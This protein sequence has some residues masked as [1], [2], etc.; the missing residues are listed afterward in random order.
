MQA[1]VLVCSITSRERV[2]SNSLKSLPFRSI[3]H[4]VLILFL[5]SLVL[6][7]AQ[8]P[9]GQLKVS[10]DTT[11]INIGDIV[12]LSLSIQYPSSAK[13]TF[14]PVGN[15]L[16]EWTVRNVKNIPAKGLKNG[17]QEVGLQ[18]QLAIYKI[19][20]FN[21]P[22]MEVELIKKNSE[23][24]VLSSAPIKIKVESILT[25][26]KQKLKDLKAQA[27]IAPDYRPFLLL[28]AAL[29]SVAFLIYWLFTTLKKR[30][31]VAMIEVLDNRTP[32]Q[33]ARDAIQALLSRRLVEQSLLKQFYLELSE[34][35]KR[36][37]G[38]KLNI[39]SLERTTEEFIRD[40][41]KTSLAL[42]DFEMIQEFLVECDLV[43]FAKYHPSPEEIQSIIQKAVQLIASIEASHNRGSRE[44]EVPA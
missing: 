2:G 4:W 29:A 44:V 41:R 38:Q 13:V 27:E 18:I 5:S 15:M 39:L 40:L 14:P 19:G 25:G 30:R 36:Y 3:P 17:I 12:T 9:S 35:V 6:T 22:A 42:Q 31:K 23:R 7:Q 11:E 28:L 20:E 16:G 21:I 43:K 33:I 24:E 34:I 8:E 10:V 32:E 37:L 26:Q 1:S